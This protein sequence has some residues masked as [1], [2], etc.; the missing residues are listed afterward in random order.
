V[1]REI[2]VPAAARAL[3]TLPEIHYEETFLADVDAA[4]D[5]SPQDWARA[6]LE[7]AP[8]KTRRALRLGWTGLGVRLGPEGSPAHVLGWEIRHA[9]AEYA[10]LAGYSPL[11]LSAELLVTYH[12]DELLFATFV[13]QR[14]PAGRALWLGI[15]PAHRRV[16]PAILAACRPT[17][18]SSSTA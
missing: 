14:N 5:R 2:E 9:D 18:P 11:G 7:G 10:L 6:I 17:T 16:V 1:V 8:A 4:R 15:E 12:E 13:Q 3:S